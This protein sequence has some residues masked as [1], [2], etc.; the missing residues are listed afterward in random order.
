MTAAEGT[1]SSANRSSWSSPTGH[2]AACRDGRSS[3]RW[4][5]CAA[6]RTAPLGRRVMIA[7]DLADDPG[8]HARVVDFGQVP[9]NA[10]RDGVNTVGVDPMP[11]QVRLTVEAAAHDDV[12]SC[13]LC[14]LS[15]HLRLATEAH[16]GAIDQEL[17]P[18][19]R[20]RPSSRAMS[21]GSCSRPVA[22]CSR[23]RLRKTCSCGSV[24]PSRSAWMGPV[25]VITVTAP[26]S[27]CG[28]SFRRDQRVR[29][30]SMGD[31]ISLT[32]S[33]GKR[34]SSSSIPSPGPAGTTAHPLRTSR[35]VR[36]RVEKPTSGAPT[37]ERGSCRWT[38]RRATWQPS[39]CWS[40]RRCEERPEHQR[41]PQRRYLE[42]FSNAVAH[43]VRLGDVDGLT[44]EPWEKRRS[45]S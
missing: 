17:P 26:G 15:Q 29:F 22:R 11:V 33:A 2:R 43:D 37:P 41:P 5:R 3:L 18:A 31:V 44:P 25:T 21:S 42:G 14:D 34:S 7:P 35:G 32:T 45:G 8:A 13:G 12:Q 4:A 28:P 27:P 30:I 38:R 1:S 40:R 9:D 24:M 36:S 39:R 6:R 16:V 20:K 19:S 23:M 10:L